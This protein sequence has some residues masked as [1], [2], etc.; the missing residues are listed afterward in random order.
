MH[1]IEIARRMAIILAVLM[2]GGWLMASN[3]VQYLHQS[4]ISLSLSLSLS[5]SYIIHVLRADY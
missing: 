4:L 2:H 5:L 3:G 1:S